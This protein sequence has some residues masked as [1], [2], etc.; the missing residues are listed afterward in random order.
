MEIRDL[1]IG[2]RFRGCSF[3]ALLAGAAIATQPA[4]ATNYTF[5]VLYSGDDSAAL[6]LG[7]DDPLATTLNPGDSFTYSLTATGD[8]EWHTIAAA[9]IF[10]L[11]ALYVLG[12][13][14]RV[15]DFTLN[16]EQ[17]GVSVFSYSETGASN[18][19]VHLGTNTVSIPSGL[20]FNAW[21]LTDTN[22]SMTELDGITDTTSTPQS[23]LPW[24]GE[25]PE[26]YSPQAI[27][28]GTV[29]EPST[30]AMMLL[31]FVGIGYAGFRASR[32]RTWPV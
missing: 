7:S 10:P 32:T 14:I 19:E 25:A 28:Y 16:L 8:G 20:T 2:H 17:N 27:T 13:G 30:W 11:F 4:A 26:I 1:A 24:P 23:L 12:P 5:D 22:T 15:G 6:A 21:V 3:A 29:P 31:G 18:S 9:D